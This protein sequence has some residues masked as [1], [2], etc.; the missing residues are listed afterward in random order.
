MVFLTTQ[1]QAVVVA[2]VGT[3]QLVGKVDLVL[4]LS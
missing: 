3:L 4:V 2:E 1:L